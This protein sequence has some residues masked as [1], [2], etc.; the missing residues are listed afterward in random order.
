MEGITQPYGILKSE[1]VGFESLTVTLYRKSVLQRPTLAS[2]FC[3]VN[4]FVIETST[5]ENFGVF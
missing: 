1:A 5:K 4:V 2:G 3:C